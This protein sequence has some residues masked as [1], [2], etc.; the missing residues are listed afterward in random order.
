MRFTEIRQTTVPISS[1]VANAYIDFSKMDISVV[2]VVTDQERD[3][4]RVV[5]YGFNSNGR[6][7]PARHLLRD[8]FI[9]ACWPRAQ[10]PDRRRE[11]QPRS[12]PHL[13]NPDDRRE[14]RWARGTLG[15][16]WRHRHGGLGRRGKIAQ[17]HSGACWLT[18]TTPARRTSAST[19]SRG[20]RLLPARQGPARPAGRDAR[21]PEHGLPHRQDE[22]PVARR[23]TRICGASRQSSRCWMAT[24]PAWPWTPMAASTWTKPLPMPRPWRLQPALVRGSG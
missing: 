19:R 9:P 6:Y 21:L 5:G 3:G 22:D 14:A 12:A 18:T 20:R 15:G 17:V 10:M 11:G 16:R 24:E 13:A 23:W 7:A 2:A 4:R 8:R 1:S